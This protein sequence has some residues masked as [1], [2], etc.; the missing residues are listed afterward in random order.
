M[1]LV[2]GHRPRRTAASIDLLIDP[3]IT[4]YLYLIAGNSPRT[5]AGPPINGFLD[6]RL[7]SDQYGVVLSNTCTAQASVEGPGDLGTAT[8]GSHVSRGRARVAFAS[9]SV[10]SNQTRAAEFNFVAAGLPSTKNDIS[11]VEA[12][13]YLGRAA[14]SGRIARGCS[15]ISK[16]TVHRVV[17]HGSSGNLDEISRGIERLV[18]GSKGAAGNRGKTCGVRDEHLVAR[19]TLQIGRSQRIGMTQ[20]DRPQGAVRNGITDDFPRMAVRG[21]QEQSRKRQGD[22]AG[23][24]K[25]G[26]HQRRETLGLIGPQF[27]IHT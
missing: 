17:D 21:T 15:K 12:T 24:K 7:V 10:P 1:D 27:G 23:L 25:M 14:E 19:H 11:T 4:E 5:V 6:P 20:T 22:R 3:R 16:T 13:L 9:H 8:Q 2:A 26:A 18:V